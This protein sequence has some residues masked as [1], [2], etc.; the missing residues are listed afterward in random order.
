MRTCVHLLLC[1]GVL[2]M[3]PL[4]ARA[5]ELKI[6]DVELAALAARAEIKSGYIEMQVA[7]RFVGE[8]KQSDNKRP[9]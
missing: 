8:R 6:P 4:A 2:G 9:A 1:F 3:S 7:T 5:E